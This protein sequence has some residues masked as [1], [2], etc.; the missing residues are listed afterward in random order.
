MSKNSKSKM[1]EY[2]EE[3]IVSMA[4]AMTEDELEVLV[5][6][7]PTGYLYNELGRRLAQNEELKE[8]LVDLIREVKNV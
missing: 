5:T 6:A 4:K 8:G 3:K 7:I 1:T 2:Q